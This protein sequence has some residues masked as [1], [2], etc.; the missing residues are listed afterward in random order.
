MT[1]TACGVLLGLAASRALADPPAGSPAAAEAKSGSAEAEAKTPRRVWG[2]NRNGVRFGFDDQAEGGLPSGW[3]DA[4]EASAS[5]K[6]SGW[7]VQHDPSAPSW[8]LSVAFANPEGAS[9][10]I[11]LL[12][13]QGH[14]RAR[15]FDLEVK[16]K[17][18]GGKLAR[19]G[20]LVWRAENP[21]NYY[22]ACWQAHEDSFQ[23]LRYKDGQMAVLGQATLKA[24]SSAWHTLGVKQRGEQM[25][26]SFDGRPLVE[27]RDATFTDDAMLGFWTR[28]DATT[29]FD[30]LKVVGH[31]PPSASENQKTPKGS[32]KE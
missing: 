22:A 30:E 29:S 2:A 8:P 23:I 15:D 13:T 12:L 3:K 28:A 6:A 1:L 10:A 27:T 11:N 31:W 17:A 16:I 25:V 7:K 5:G 32:K 14:Q 4:A 20:G 24:D 18:T 21:Q 9:N 26:A 19:G